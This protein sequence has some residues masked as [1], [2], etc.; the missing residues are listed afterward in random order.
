MAHAVLEGFETAVS[1]MKALLVQG[2][3]ERKALKVSPR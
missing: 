2:L 1:E 3:R